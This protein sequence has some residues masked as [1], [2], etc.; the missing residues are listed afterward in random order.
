MI[1][2]L[3][4]HTNNGDVMKNKSIWLHDLNYQPNASLTENIDV[5]V[6][7]IGG[8]ITGLSVAYELIN[9]NLKVC[10]VE[11][12]SI[13]HSTT[14]KSTGK[15]TFLQELIY[16]DL[17]KMYDFETS[18]KYNES[19]QFAIKHAKDIIYENKID[20]FLE[21]VSSYVFTNIEKEIDKIKEEY[22]I[23][24]KMGIDVNATNK[25]P[26][27]SD[28]LLGISVNNTY[29]FHPLKYLIKLKDIITSNGIKIYENTNVLK[30]DK[31][32][33]FLVS[34]DTYQIKA[35]KIVLALHYPYFLFPYLMPLKVHLEKSY[36]AAYKVNDNK[37]FSAITSKKPTTSIRY[38]TLEKTYKI[39]LNGS[40]NLS[41]D[42]NYSKK[43]N[44]LKK[45][46]GDKPDYIWSNRDI[47]TSDKLP[48]IG[49]LDKNLYI[50]TGYNTWGITNG[51]L[52]GVIIKDKILNKNNPYS[53]LFNPKRSLKNKIINYPINICSSAISF[54]TSKINKNKSF[55]KSSVYFENGLG[56]YITKDGKKHIVYNKCPHLGCSLIFNEVEKTWD[57]PCHGSRFNI[58]GKVIDGPSNYDI[59]Y[60]RKSSK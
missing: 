37:M 6:L 13:G 56:I 36:I 51:I 27:K 21:K 24:K 59:S 47:I 33:D 11:R 50:G 2:K 9:S 28:I 23:L 35:K 60:K 1:F 39:C 29:V 38:T 4:S 17:N 34:T 18:R 57:C 19:Q 42:N 22:D 5:D 53:E 46:F 15:L 25:L 16:S 41:F 58:D 10:L 55:Y 30:I 44:K 8:G 7:I 31:K 45:E 14:G 3:L 52:A 48:L 40:H 43:F 32:D 20:C 26:D 12:N 49:E 54:M